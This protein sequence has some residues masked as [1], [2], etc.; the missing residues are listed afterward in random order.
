MNYFAR[1]LLSPALFFWVTILSAQTDLS[2]EVQVY[3]TG[4]LPGISIDQ[5]LSEKGVFYARVG[6]N[7]FDHRDLGVQEE[8][9]GSGWGFSLGYKNYFKDGQVGWRWGIKNDF[10]WNRV[11]WRTGNETGETSITV[12]QP[13]AE[14]SY[15]IRKNSFYLAPSLAL[16]FEWNVQTDGE[17]TGE[18]AILLV[19]VQM[20]MNINR[21]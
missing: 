19:G 7:L 8:E 18:G 4:V 20:G 12:L 2:V 3:P 17:P 9:E 14:L 6:A 15:V 13:T 16:G 5:A 11:D 1:L 10:W 21:K